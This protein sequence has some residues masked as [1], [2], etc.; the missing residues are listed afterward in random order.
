MC[1]YFLRSKDYT[2]PV[3]FISAGLRKGEEKK[4]Q[5]DPDDSEESDDGG[6]AAPPPPSR[7]VAPKKLQTVFEKYTCIHEHA[8]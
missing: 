2:A 5:K 3:S 4:Q 7:G 1:A 6:S 8:A